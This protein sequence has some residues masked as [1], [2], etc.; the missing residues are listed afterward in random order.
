MIHTDG[1]TIRRDAGVSKKCINHA[2]SK[3]QNRSRG[4][5]C[6]TCVACI[7][8]NTKNCIN[9]HTSLYNK[10]TEDIL[11]IAYIQLANAM[12]TQHK[13]T[14]EQKEPGMSGLKN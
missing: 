2:T 13:K 10:I 4:D 12:H 6:K 1:K 11:H 5:I 8:E 3:S 7:Q 9:I 14:S